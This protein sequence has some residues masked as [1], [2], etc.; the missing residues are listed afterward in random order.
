MTMEVSTMKTKSDGCELTGIEALRYL[1]S[2]AELYGNCCGQ[3]LTLYVWTGDIAPDHAEYILMGDDPC[4]DQ[5]DYGK[6]LIAR[7]EPGV[8]LWELSVTPKMEDVIMS[9]PE[10]REFWNPT[11]K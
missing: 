1:A 8:G 2:F 3:E 4:F 9:K 6:A 10:L 5:Q 11:K 7:C